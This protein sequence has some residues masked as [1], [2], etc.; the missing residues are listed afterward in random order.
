M[1]RNL[2]RLAPLFDALVIFGFVTFDIG[3][4]AVGVTLLYVTAGARA[5]LRECADRVLPVASEVS[6]GRAPAI[7]RRADGPAPAPAG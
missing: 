4:L 3:W 1:L 7:S 2:A 6:S 5:E